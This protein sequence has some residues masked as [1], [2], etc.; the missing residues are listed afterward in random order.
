MS[1]G[2]HQVQG[3][4][5]SSLILCDLSD[6][7]FSPLDPWLCDKQDWPTIGHNG[8][9]LGP[10]QNFTAQILDSERCAVTITQGKVSPVLRV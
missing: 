4:T 9:G 3:A 2:G 10:A 7:H 6:N 5:V 1:Q 8:K